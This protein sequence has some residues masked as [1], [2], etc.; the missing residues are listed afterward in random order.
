[1]R[2]ANLAEIH[3]N[4]K[5]ASLR[6]K[7]AWLCTFVSCTFKTGINQP[8]RFFYSLLPIAIC[9]AWAAHWGS[10]YSHLYRELIVIGS[11]VP[12]IRIE[13]TP[14][15]RILISEQGKQHL[16]T[17]MLLNKFTFFLINK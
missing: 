10:K 16:S 4:P 8:L 14:G 9:P 1:M 3:K 7:N 2:E 11:S 17:E 15:I 12:S 5:L 13:T 6:R